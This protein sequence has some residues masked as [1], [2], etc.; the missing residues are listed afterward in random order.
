[1]AR[2]ISKRRSFEAKTGQVK[3]ELR[4]RKLKTSPRHHAAFVR[5]MSLISCRRW[6]GPNF[7]LPAVRALQR[8]TSSTLQP[9]HALTMS[10]SA[11]FGRVLELARFERRFCHLPFL[12]R[13]LCHV[14]SPGKPG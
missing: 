7:G 8:S 14:I 3:N 5:L 10:R 9:T 11:D 1:M 6:R 12:S 13:Q 2:R 4:T